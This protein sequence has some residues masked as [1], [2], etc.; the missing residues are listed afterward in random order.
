MLKKMFSVKYFEIIFLLFDLFLWKATQNS[1]KLIFTIYCNGEKI[2]K[3]NGKNAK[4]RVRY[5]AFGQA[6]HYYSASA[7]NFI[8]V[9][10]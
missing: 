7:K 6:F 10:P 5:S 2:G 3:I 1:K 9:H 4:H 8:S